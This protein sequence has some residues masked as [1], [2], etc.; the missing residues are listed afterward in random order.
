[1]ADKIVGIAN[2]RAPRDEGPDEPSHFIN[3]GGLS[4]ETGDLALNSVE[5][6]CQTQP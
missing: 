3:V 2:A 5:L 1:M 4:V 6:L